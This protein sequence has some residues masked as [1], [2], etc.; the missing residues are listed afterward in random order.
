[1]TGLRLE[2]REREVAAVGGV[3]EEEE[4]GLLVHGQVL[5]PPH[6]L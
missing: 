3:L 5:H 1:V 4:D 2:G 6:R